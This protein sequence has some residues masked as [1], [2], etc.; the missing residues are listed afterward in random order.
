MTGTAGDSVVAAGFEPVAAAFYATIPDGR[1]SGAALSVW[2]DGVPVLELAAGTA[3]ETTGRRFDADTLVNVFS[4]T[5]GWASTLVAMLVETGALPGYDTPLA[6]VWP[7]FGAQGKQRIT[8]G[9]ALAHR[10]GVSAPRVELTPEQL[11]DPLQMADLLAAQEPLWEPGTNHQYHGITHGALTAKLVTIATGA[12][13][14]SVFADLVARPLEADAWIGLPAAEHDRVALLLP[15]AAP[16][17]AESDPD[18]PAEAETLGDPMAYLTGDRWLEPAVR[19]AQIPGAGGIA[20]AS[21]VARIWSATVTP[22]RGVRLLRDETVEALRRQRSHGPAVIAGP[23]PYQAWGA[24]VMVPSDWEPYLSARSFGHDGAGGQVAFA[25]PEFRVGF[26][27]L[28]NQMGDWQRGQ[29]VVAALGA[30]L[31]S[32]RRV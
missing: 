14:G 32:G 13:I 11:L 22:T 9:D 18:A 15:E 21:A 17:V 26:G 24:G 27:Y 4:C 30:V 6:A 20:T 7:E 19:E 3:V 29:S 31:R 25:D 8:I 2:V 23:P 28:V 16:P 12:D 10:G 5:K 1:R